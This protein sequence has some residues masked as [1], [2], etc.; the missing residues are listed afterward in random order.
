MERIDFTTDFFKFHFIF[1]LLS[2]DFWLE[3]SLLS[4]TSKV[5]LW[6]E[7]LINPINREIYAITVRVTF[8]LVFF[9]VIQLKL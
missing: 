9:N 2:V 5:I 1:L 4:S 3:I 6:L 8:D 7:M